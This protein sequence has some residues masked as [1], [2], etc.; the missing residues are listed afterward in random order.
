M[1]RHKGHGMILAKFILV[2]N[3][4]NKCLLCVVYVVCVGVEQNMPKSRNNMKEAIFVLKKVKPSYLTM[5][6]GDVSL[7]HCYLTISDF[8]LT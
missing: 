1:V 8:Y 2:S 6:R 7:S 5:H 4:H 3:M